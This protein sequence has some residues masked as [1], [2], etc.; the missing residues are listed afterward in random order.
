MAGVDATDMILSGTAAAG[1]SVG[2]VT[3]LGGHTWR[4]P[5]SGLGN[6]TLNIAL[7][8]DAGDV[9]AALLGLEAEPVTTS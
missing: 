5:V 9:L 6:G 4:F 7:A 3:D 2:A 1:A 8:P